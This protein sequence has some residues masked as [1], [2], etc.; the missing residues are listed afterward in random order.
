MDIKSRGIVVIGCVFIVTIFSCRACAVDRVPDVAKTLGI[1][2]VIGS[3][4]TSIDFYGK[5][6][7]QDD[8]P[9]EGAVVTIHVR[10]FSPIPPFFMGTKYLSSKTGQDGIFEVHPGRGLDLFITKFSKE[11]YEFRFDM[12]P[13]NGFQYG[14]SGGEVVFVPDKNNPVIFRLRKKLQNRTY[15]FKDRD[16]GFRIS[17]DQPNTWKATDTVEKRKI[18]PFDESDGNEHEVTCDL[19]YRAV[20]DEEAKEWSVYFSACGAEGGVVVGPEEL[21]EAPKEGYRDEWRIVIPVGVVRKRD[22]D[23]PSPCLY[24]KSRSPSIYSKVVVKTI[25]SDPDMIRMYGKMTTNP[26]GDRVLDS[27]DFPPYSTEPEIERI[28]QV[29]DRLEE[30]AKAAL[31]EGRLPPRPKIMALIEAAKRGEE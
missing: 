16:W 20:L 8:R 18:Q 17:S 6:L 21:Y 30:E 5:L 11:G 23:P 10:H 1:G 22:H 2:A 24:I 14:G 15:L 31:R 29:G 26:Y 13:E 7:D 27:V 9:I 25:Y 12:N 19:K 3:L 4:S 28:Y